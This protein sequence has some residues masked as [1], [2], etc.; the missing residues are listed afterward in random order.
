M[1]LQIDNLDGI[2]FRDYTASIDA[3]RLPR[4]V[5]RLNQPSELVF[6]LVAVTPDFV[7][8]VNGARVILGRTNGQDVFTGYL[9]APP[10][11]EFLGW[12]EQGPAYRY[13]LVAQSDEVLLDQKR[14]P[15]RPPFVGRSAGEALRQLTEDLLAGGFDTSGVQDLETLALYR[16]DPQKTWSEHASAIALLARGSYRVSGGK[17]FFAPIGAAVYVLD[18]SDANFSPGNLKLQPLDRLLNDVTAIGNVEPQ[19]YVRDYFVGTGTS[20]K[21]YLSQTPFTG[22]SQTLFIEEFSGAGLDP[23][24][25]TLAD[26]AGVVTVSQGKLHVAGGTGIDGGTRVDFIEQVELGGAFV[27]QHGDVLFTAASDAVIGGLYPGPV[28][29]AG[30][31]AGFRISPNGPQSTI[32][33]IV[34]GVT[35]GPV[36]STVAAHHYVFTT[37]FYS[38]EI[39]RRQQVFHSAARPAGNGRG[40]AEIPADVR[41]VLEVHEI[42]PA[43][44]ASLVATAT[45]LYDGLIGG[46]PTS[47]TYALVNA[48]NL[49]CEIAFTRLVRAID[50]EVRSAPQ[51]AGYRTRLVGA[52]S[53]GAQCTVVSGPTLDFFPQYVP[54]P[55]ELIEVRYRGTGRAMARVSNPANQP[56]RLRQGDDGARAAVKHLKLPAAR[57]AADC[58]NAALALLDDGVATGWMGEYETWGDFLPGSAQDIFPGDAVEVHAQSRTAN[59]QAIVRRVEIAVKDLSQDHSWYKIAFADDAADNPACT[60]EAGQVVSTPNVTELTDTQ[61]GTTFLPELTAAAINGVTSTTVTV[62]VGA[63]PPTG[64]GIEVRWTDAGWGPDNDR[65]LAGRFSTRSFTLPRLSRV[66]DYFLRPYDASQPPKYSRYSVALHIDFPYEYLP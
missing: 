17:L 6:S 25:W 47:C 54:A 63:M 57:T 59:F 61:V 33:A 34:A 40:G 29:V 18:E 42:D 10:V 21:F 4:V 28:S 55:G 50:T 27:L 23:V 53:D 26:A 56:Q 46:A 16:A 65:N 52:L 31:L 49:H 1:K 60:F 9:T 48:G 64:G 43:N 37:R 32:Q 24:R 20:L 8:P 66:E 38:L 11:Y 41:V 62:D 13:N 19:A 36:I 44:P 3:S 2:G 39:Y 12:R 58:E 7:V 35:T 51:G 30:C 15:D 45:V 14:P 5:R 22:H